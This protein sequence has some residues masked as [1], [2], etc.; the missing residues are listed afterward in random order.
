MRTLAVRSWTAVRDRLADS[1]FEACSGIASFVNIK[2]RDNK[3][4]GRD[5]FVGLSAA[6][7]LTA[8]DRSPVDH[9]VIW[10]Y[11]S[12]AL[13]DKGSLGVGVGSRPWRRTPVLEAG[14]VG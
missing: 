5:V 8:R 1:R 6:A 2:C 14:G 9:R 7:A 11:D 3:K 4:S 13:N 10:V 12:K